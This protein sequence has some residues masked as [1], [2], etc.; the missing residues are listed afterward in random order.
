MVNVYHF[1]HRCTVVTGGRRCPVKICYL[2][3]L[4]LLV[5]NLTTSSLPGRNGNKTIPELLFWCLS[6]SGR[7]REGNMV[8]CDVLLLKGQCIVDESMLTGE[9]V[10]QMKVHHRKS[11]TPTLQLSQSSIF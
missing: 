10:P 6:L 3:T 1:V 9:S 2:A 4:S 8:P 5:S 11:L 7:S